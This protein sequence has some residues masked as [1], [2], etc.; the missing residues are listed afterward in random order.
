MK[1]T[2]TNEEKLEEYFKAVRMRLEGASR[3]EVVNNTNFPSWRVLEFFM[4]QNN[5]TIPSNRAIYNKNVD[6]RFFDD[7]DSV[8]KAYILG[9]IYADGCIYDNGRFGFCLAYQDID[10]LYFIKDK[11]QILSDVKI[12]HNKKGSINR[13]PQCVLRVSSVKIVKRLAE[14]GIKRNKTLNEGLLFPDFNNDLITAFLRGLSDGDGNLYYVPGD[15]STRINSKFRWTICMTDEP[16]LKKV[17]E[18]LD[19]NNITTSLYKK[20]GKICD[21]YTLS[22]NSRGHTEKLCELIYSSN[23]FSLNRKLHKYLS[24]KN[25][26]NTVL[27]LETKESKPM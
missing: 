6:V 1:Y 9:F 25:L 7:I 10:I 2:M 15:N 13:Q 3:E 12:H 17:Q 27:S 4:T 20:K 23:G 19:S 26:D 16:F 8:D 14:F 5:L 11:M 24:Y 22:T 18:Y 21:F